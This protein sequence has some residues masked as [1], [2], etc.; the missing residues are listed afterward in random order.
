[1]KFSSPALKK[2]IISKY[3][4]ISNLKK[5]LKSKAKYQYGGYYNEVEVFGC[6]ISY[7]DNANCF[8]S[9]IISIPHVGFISQLALGKSSL[10]K[11]GLQRLAGTNISNHYLSL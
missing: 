10:T 5:F 9:Y 1:M 11:A 2:E 6:K 3:G 4:S 8:A 7:N